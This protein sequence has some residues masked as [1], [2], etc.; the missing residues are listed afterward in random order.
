MSLRVTAT[1]LKEDRLGHLL[2]PG[3]AGTITSSVERGEW[4]SVA[5]R[6]GLSTTRG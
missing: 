1:R 4:H 2:D 5:R 3:H 6:T